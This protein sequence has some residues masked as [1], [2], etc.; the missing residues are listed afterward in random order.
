VRGLRHP[1]IVWAAP[2]RAGGRA[3]GGG[4]DTVSDS[5][6]NASG[7]SSTYKAAGHPVKA[8]PP[9]AA[10]GVVPVA[11]P[12]ADDTRLIRLAT[13][14][15]GGIVRAVLILA[16]CAIGLYLTWRVRTVIRLVAISLFVALSQIT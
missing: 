15:F 12:V 7:R 14:S 3:R 5:S 4:R 9:P 6:T 10:P 16:V 8:A 13:P 11:V 2:G 1:V